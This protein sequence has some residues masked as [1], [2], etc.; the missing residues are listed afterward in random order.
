MLLPGP[1]ALLPPA[2]VPWTER[3]R[4]GDLG[5]GDLLPTDEDDAAARAGLERGGDQ[6]R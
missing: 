4:P 2:W 1:D 5:V 3:L 6:Q